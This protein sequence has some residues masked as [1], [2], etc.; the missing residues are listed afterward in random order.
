M[1]VLQL[2]PTIL[3]EYDVFAASVTS[4]G[5]MSAVYAQTL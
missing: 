4:V 3:D 5:L 1:R 2:L